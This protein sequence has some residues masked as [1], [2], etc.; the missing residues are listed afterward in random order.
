MSFKPDSDTALLSDSIPY[1]TAEYYL[2]DFD[3][4]VSTLRR[5]WE[6]VMKP[7]MIQAVLGTE[8]PDEET[9][10]ELEAEIDAYIEESTGIQT[11]LQMTWLSG[12]VREKGFTEPLKPM[13]Y[14]EIYTVE[15]GRYIESRKKD[16]ASGNKDPY[17]IPGA[18]DFL[19][20]VR[21]KGKI[22]MLTS[23]TDRDF[24]MEEAS[25]LGVDSYFNG[26]IFGSLDDVE[27][28][29]KKKVIEDLIRE[30]NI[31]GEHLVVTGDGP[32]EIRCARK[33]GGLG[34]GVTCNEETLAGAD[35]KKVQ[36]LTQAGADLLIT[37]FVNKEYIIEFT[38]AG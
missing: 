37:D 34:I 11:I 33:A 26:G 27:K 22:C 21:E 9:R 30:K 38:A 1:H 5:G 25:L 20:S 13:E 6:S 18:V 2:F 14:K 29:S 36:R 19:A 4:T 8:T 24:V 17:L 35:Q 10:K 15:L 12:F 16:A 28:Y 7:V 23:G 32:V 31:S 3:G